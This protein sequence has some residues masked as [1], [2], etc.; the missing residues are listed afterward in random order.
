MLSDTFINN[1]IQQFGKPD[2]LHAFQKRNID[3][4]ITTIPIIK[5]NNLTGVLKIYHTDEDS[6]RVNFFS[7]ENINAAI[8]AELDTKDFQLYKGAVQSLIIVKLLMKQPVDSKYITWLSENLHRATERV[9]W[10]CIELWDFIYTSHMTGWSGKSD[11]Y[12]KCASH[13]YKLY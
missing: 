4:K 9:R 12:N 13:S 8:E 10:H 7:L 2:Y 5:S 3:L 6:I 1:F 11:F